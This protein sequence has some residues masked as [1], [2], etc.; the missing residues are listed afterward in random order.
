[1]FD[2]SSPVFEFNNSHCYYLDMA[3]RAVATEAVDTEEA[4]AVD[5]VVDREDMVVV[6]AAMAATERKPKKRKIL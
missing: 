3:E 2:Q 5:T 1:M 6:A 4:R